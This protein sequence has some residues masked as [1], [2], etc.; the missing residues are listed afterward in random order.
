MSELQYSIDARGDLAAEVFALLEEL[1]RGKIHGVAYDTAWIARLATRYPGYDFEESIEWLR[2]NQHEDG[3]WGASQ[4]HYHD[5]FVSTLAAVVALQE[6]GTN[7]RDA[8]RVQRGEDALWKLA[9]HLGRDASDTVGFPII[10]TSLAQ[11]A[12]ELG[13]D[14]PRFP[15]RYEAAYKRKV[16]ALLAQPNRD[17][18]FNVI[19]FSFEGLWRTIDDGDQ[20]LEANYSVASSPAATA[21]YLLNYPHEGALNYLKSVREED[22]S[23]PAFAPND[24]FE[25]AWAL[26]HLRSMGIVDPDMPVVRQVLDHVWEKWSPI[27]GAHYSSYF[28][29]PDLDITAACFSILR[30]GGYPVEADVFEY[31]E[32]EDHFCNYRNET[33]PSATAHLR[34]LIAL[35]DCPEHPRQPEWV[36]KVLK[37]LHRFNQN[38]ALWSDKWHTSSYYVSHLAIRALHR[39]DPE[40]AES[41]LKW[42]I[43]TQHADGGWGYMGASTPEETAY[44][45]DS[46][47]L[48]DRTVG[49]IDP[50]IIEKGVSFLSFH[51]DKRHYT[52]LWISKVLYTPHNI[53]KAA[54]LSAL[55]Q[56]MEW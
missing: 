7:G 35:Q 50:A 19:S 3:T 40:L 11:D 8:R 46:L 21:A 45:I 17:W 24:I 41:H 43:K 5:R 31:F 38:D 47:L 10:S 22:G 6:A 56:Y 26:N 9:T 48:W 32:M 42:I 28:Q 30:W 53:V 2:H 44:C 15:I 39:L 1:G 54:I 18:R 55:F 51:N 49:R 37:A 52:P 29:V 14:I 13:L 12:T 4:L 36:E 20:V 23:V 33:N 25:I 16:Q 27:T 34:L